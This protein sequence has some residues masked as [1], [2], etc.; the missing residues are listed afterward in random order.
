MRCSEYE[1]LISAFADGELKGTLLEEVRAHIAV[2]KD[3]LRL[4]RETCLLQDDVA[5]ALDYCGEVPDLV[6]VVSR[7]I[8][9]KRRLNLWPLWAA[10]AALLFIVA[11]GYTLVS[12]RH[13]AETIVVTAPVPKVKTS[14]APTIPS[15]PRDRPKISV[16]SC[17]GKNPTK[18][19]RP[20][21]VIVKSR[22]NRKSVVPEKAIEHNPQPAPMAVA[23]AEVTVEYTDGTTPQASIHIDPMEVVGPKPPG[24][25]EHVPGRVVAIRDLPLPDGLITD[26][27]YYKEM[28]P[29]SEDNVKSDNAEKETSK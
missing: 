10:A 6:S 8:A 13:V 20:H 12:K 11:G 29:K 7:R 16:A 22:V 17:N 5:S 3:C 28:Q 19:I 9:P 25:D 18:P 1:Q 26:R 27:F 23:V 24:P 21:S 14:P 4:Y 2:C 15:I